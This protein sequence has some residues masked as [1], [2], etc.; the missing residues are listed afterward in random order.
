[1]TLQALASRRTGPTRLATQLQARLPGLADALDAN[2]ASERIESTLLSNAFRVD[3]TTVGSLWYRVDGT[4]ALRYRLVVSSADGLRLDV[5]VL[6]RVCPG[7]DGVSRFL[8]RQLTPMLATTP[9][10]PP[11]PWRR[12]VADW[13]S[14]G[15]ALHVFPIDPEIPTLPAVLADGALDPLLPDVHPV[16]S[17]VVRHS[18]Y[19]TCVLRYELGAA[20]RT[21][22]VYGKVYGNSAGE[23]AYRYLRFASAPERS[24]MGADLLGI[25]AAVGYRSSL[26]VLVTEAVPGEPLLPTLVRDAQSADANADAISHVCEAVAAAG[27][28]LATL[29]VR[30]GPSSPMRAVR[31]APNVAAELQLLAPVWPEIAATIGSLL[32]A[33]PVARQFSA[34]PVWCH[35]DFTPSQVLYPPD[36]PCG[37][38]D[39]DTASWGDPAMDLGRFIAHLDLLVSKLRG[40]PDWLFQAQLATAFLRGYADAAGRLRVESALL[41]RV[42][43]YRTLSLARSAIHAC[44]QLKQ[45]RLSTALSLLNTANSWSREVSP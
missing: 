25:P 3:S 10:R 31:A 8:N 20:P 14:S 24:R 33:G 44:R 42:A 28:A 38:V 17:T 45:A 7:A 36:G 23:N 1:M 39:F 19:G 27:R 29:H 43:A 26:R 6:G 16:Q 34:A 22:S 9:V 41:Q 18:R 2:A 5:S 37:V 30:G 11:D 40:S 32:A 4:C 15:L 13:Q 21:R 35:G 12:W